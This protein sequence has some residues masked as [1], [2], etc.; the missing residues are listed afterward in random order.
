MKLTL[1]VAGIA[2]A[3]P[4]FSFV[5]Q[6]L[7]GRPTQT[8]DDSRD[9]S[10]EGGK[11]ALFQRLVRYYNREFHPQQHWAYGCNCMLM[12]GDKGLERS[13]YGAPVDD[14]DKVCKKLTDCY[15]CV[16]Q[17]FGPSCTPETTEY[18]IF[19]RGQEILVGNRPG[20]CERALYECDLQ[21]SKSLGTALQTFN[22]QYNFFYGF[23]PIS[24]KSVCS[25]KA[26]VSTDDTSAVSNSG[27]GQI[28]DVQLDVQC[29]GSR[30]SYYQTYNSKLKQCCRNGVV[31]DLSET[32]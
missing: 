30:R 24:D 26:T 1:I 25:N 13:S 5:Q 21:Y 8:K 17:Q 27:F 6:S 4:L 22:M 11:Y 9:L 15:K 31:K 10:D 19:F 23:D 12:I 3:N 2:S 32:C 16:R 29:C 28:R 20:T 7:P 14:M 18:D